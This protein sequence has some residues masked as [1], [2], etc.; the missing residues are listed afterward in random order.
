MGSW[1]PRA[2]W[3][4][5]HCTN[6]LER[7]SAKIER[8]T[9]VV[10]IFPNDASIIRLLGEMVLERNDECCCKAKAKAKATIQSATVAP[11][12]RNAAYI[13]NEAG[14]NRHLRRD[15]HARPA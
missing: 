11:Q 4:Q 12:L 3:T 15:L 8:R 6:P 5:V 1:L 2:H 13:S 14:V 10:G 9:R 7:L